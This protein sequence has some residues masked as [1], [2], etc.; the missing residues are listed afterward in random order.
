MARQCFVGWARTSAKGGPLRDSEEFVSILD[1]I[2]NY[3]SLV[4]FAELLGGIGFTQTTLVTNNV[5][6]RVVEHHFSS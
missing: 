6:I 1:V 2:K 5:F 4:E 3:N